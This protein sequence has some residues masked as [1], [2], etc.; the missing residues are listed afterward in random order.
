MTIIATVVIVPNAVDEF[1]ALEKAE[2]TL[3][4]SAIDP[5]GEG[6]LNE[7]GRWESVAPGWM[8]YAMPVNTKTRVE[9]EAIQVKDLDIQDFFLDFEEEQD[10]FIPEALVLSDGEWADSETIAAGSAWPVYFVETIED[11]PPETWLVFVEASC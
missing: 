4:I 9:A 3:E 10:D 2:A 11:L 8:D 5:F 6:D 7:F 1:D